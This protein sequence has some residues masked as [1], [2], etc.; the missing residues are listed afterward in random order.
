MMTTAKQT[1]SFSRQ[2]VSRMVQLALLS[3]IIVVMAFTPLGYLKIGVLSIT[4]I[5]IPV[6]VGAILMG[7][8]GGAFLGGVF[9]VTSF[10]QCFGMDAFGTTLFGINP[11]FTFLMCVGAR[12]LMG[13]LTGL[14]FR[15]LYKVDSTKIWSFAVA[16]LSGAVLNTVLFMGCLVLFFGR[17][18]YI[19]D[20]QA[21]MGVQSVM[22]FLVAMVGVNGVM[23]AAVCLVAGSAI[24]KALHTFLTRR[25][26]A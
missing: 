14:I 4:F 18:E 24:S 23:E 2:K 7:P 20:M 22:G 17:S 1:G 8:G 12:I 9:G 25:S 5:T 3:A 6:V 21:T 19:L 11:V 26:R 16:S 15:A 10:V 13:F